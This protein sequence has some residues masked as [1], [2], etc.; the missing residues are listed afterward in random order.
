[1]SPAS[2]TSWD[3]FA[4]RR[5]IFR[6][7]ERRASL[8]LPLLFVASAIVHAFGFYVF[9][10]V[11]PPTGSTTPQPAQVTFLA[12]TPE[13][14]AMLRWAES[15]DPSL[16]A[17]MQ[18]VTPPGLGEVRYI[19]SYATE[20]ALPAALEEKPK[21]TVFPPARDLSSLLA[22]P[23]KPCAAGFGAVRT[24]FCFG[25]E[26]RKRDAGGKTVFP[27]ISKNGETLRPS[28]F[29]LSIDDRGEVRYCFLQESCGEPE[30][31]KAAET[32]LR[33]HAFK[34]TDTPSP[35]LWGFATVDWGIEAYA[36]PIPA[37]AGNAGVRTK[38]AS[39]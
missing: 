37:Q 19:P 10:V 7:P 22:A 36:S 28:E 27:A 12:D 6:W 18:E 34:H 3:P 1:M 4:I 15:Q 21:T 9:Q 38:R 30:M 13:N 24:K 8:M 11:Y 17:R 35:L 20:H 23:T 33:Q 25:E 2:H 32:V 39:Q 26:L 14:D 16:A 31:D 29:L 5:L